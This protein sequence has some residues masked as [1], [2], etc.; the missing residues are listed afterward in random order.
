MANQPA[1]SNIRV[2]TW[3]EFDADARKIA[4]TI[5]AWGRTFQWIYGPPRGGTPLAVRLSHLLLSD[6]QR[7]KT[8]EIQF[9]FTPVIPDY[10]LDFINTLLIVDDIADTGKTLQSF[11]ENGFFIATLFKHPQSAITPD[12]WIHEKDYRWIQF[13]WEAP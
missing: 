6:E 11:K 9:V 12:I 4:D 3:E 13:P 5:K 2:Y 1:D 7:Q 8:Q 10:Y